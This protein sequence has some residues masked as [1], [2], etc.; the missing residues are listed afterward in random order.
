MS[1]GAVLGI[2]AMRSWE[3]AERPIVDHRPDSRAVGA[4][5]AEEVVAER[6]A[7]GMVVRSGDLSERET[8]LVKNEL[9][10]R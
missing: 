4:C 6:Q 7:A 2:G 1:G 3:T 9:A 5:C 8:A 10:D